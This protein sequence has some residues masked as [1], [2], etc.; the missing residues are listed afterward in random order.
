M[1]T[2]GMATAELL[3][4]WGTP[5]GIVCP[6][7]G[8]AIGVLR[9]C[10]R[11]GLKVPEDVGMVGFDDIRDLTETVRPTLSSIRVPWEELGKEAGRRVIEE[12]FHPRQQPVIIT[13]PVTLIA[14]Q[15]S[16]LQKNALFFDL[17]PALPLASMRSC[18]PGLHRNDHSKLLSHETLDPRNGGPQKLDAPMVD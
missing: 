10:E 6:N 13:C 17:H 7:D 8:A 15:S 3:D 2:Q 18:G 16:V 11:R 4:R 5:L 1:K 12:L 9:E 14:R